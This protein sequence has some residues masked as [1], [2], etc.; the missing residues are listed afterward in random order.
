MRL[1]ITR[2]LT[3]PGVTNGAGL[4]RRWVGVDLKI[5]GTLGNRFFHHSFG[6][7]LMASSV[8]HRSKLAGSPPFPLYR[9]VDHKQY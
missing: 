1:V 4:G 6:S 7:S 2:V 9:V 8:G 3:E 5:F